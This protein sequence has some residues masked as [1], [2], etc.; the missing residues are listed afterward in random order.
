MLRKPQRRTQNAGHS[1]GKWRL[2]GRQF[3]PAQTPDVR[4]QRPQEDF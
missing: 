1:V 4:T 3:T 2:G